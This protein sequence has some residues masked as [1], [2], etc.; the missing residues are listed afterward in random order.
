[1]NPSEHLSNRRKRFDHQAGDVLLQSRLLLLF[2]KRAIRSRNKPSKHTPIDEMASFPVGMDMR[3]KHFSLPSVRRKKC[4]DLCS[5]VSLDS[6]QSFKVAQFWGIPV[7]CGTLVYSPV[8][9]VSSISFMTIWLLCDIKAVL[10]LV[11]HAS[12][13]NNAATFLQSSIE[14]DQYIRT[15]GR[16]FDLSFLNRITR[17]YTS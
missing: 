11:L 6:F 15:W 1:M 3:V 17:F 7:I 5:P 16:V 8:E 4:S 12:L 14:I 13:E 10:K 2:T 9:M